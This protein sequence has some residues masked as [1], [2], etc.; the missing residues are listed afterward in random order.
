MDFQQSNLMPKPAALANGEHY[1]S[2]S[3]CLKLADY[4][5]RKAEEDLFSLKRKMRKLLLRL[6]ESYLI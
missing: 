2:Y 5:I 1:F 4:R 6:E 3:A